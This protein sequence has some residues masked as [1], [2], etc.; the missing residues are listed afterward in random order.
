MLR[1]SKLADYATVVMTA[2]AREPDAVHSAA[3]LSA[4]LDVAAPTMSKILKML[5]REELVVSVRGASGGYRLRAPPSEISVAQVIRA[6]DGP[7]GM[8]ECS[9]IPGLCSQEKRCTVRDNWMRV[10]EIVLGVLQGITLEQMTRPAPGTVRVEAIRGRRPK[11][12]Q[13]G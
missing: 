3:G 5:A 6:M 10:N 13:L 4:R 1:I 8:T 7:I 2:M 9:S 12:E 11:V